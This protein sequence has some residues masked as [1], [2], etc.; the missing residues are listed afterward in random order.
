MDINELL[1]LDKVSASIKKIDLFLSKTSKSDTT[2][3][4][5]IA[6]KGIILGEI[7]RVNEALKLLYA[8]VPIF[9]QLDYNAVIYLCN[10]I[11]YICKNNYLVDQMAKYIEIKK[12]YLPLAR[13]NE[14]KIDLVDYYLL[15]NNQSKIKE[16][17]VKILAEETD[18]DVRAKYMA[19][20]A[21]IYFKE[22]DYER[23][24]S[25]YDNLFSYYNKNLLFDN[26]NEL[27]FK[28][29]RI[30]YE[31]GNYI[32]AIEM[33]KD[34]LNDEHLS[35]ELKINAAAICVRGYLK[36]KEYRRATIIVTDYEEELDKI[37]PIDGKEFVLAALDL[38]KEQ[39][40]LISIKEYEDRLNKI[41]SS[42]EY[43]NPKKKK[44]KQI[45]IPEIAEVI[46]EQPKQNV[47]EINILKNEK[48]DILVSDAYEKF[49]NVFSYINSRDKNLKFRE[50]FRL[51]AIEL[52]KLFPIDEIV[53]V[54][55]NQGYF[56]YHYK[57]ERVYNKAFNNKD[58]EDT[59]L[60]T[61]IE[62]EN[63]AYKEGEG[64]KN[65]ITNSLYEEKK[66]ILCFP[67]FEDTIIMG[68]IA[69]VSNKR[70]IDVDMAYEILKLT[71]QMLNVRLNNEMYINEI[72]ATN[73]KLFFISEAMSS[74]IK[75]EASGY[76][77]S[78]AKACELLNVYENLNTSDYESKIEA[79]DLIMYRKA[80]EEALANEAL[81]VVSRYHFHKGNEVIYV[82]ERFYPMLENKTYT[83]ISLIDDIT[84]EEKTKNDL[85]ALIYENPLSKLSGEAKL[86]IDLTDAIKNKKFSIALIDIN[87]FKLYTDIYGLS[88]T[89]QLI[90]HLGLVIKEEIST[91]FNTRIYHL[92]GDKFALLYLDLNDKRLALSKTLNYLDIFTKKMYDVNKRIKL[93]FAAGVYRYTANQNI[94]DPSKILSY[95][96]YGLLDAKEVKDGLN[97]VVLFDQRSYQKRYFDFQL[98]TH[99]S[100]CIDHNKMKITYKQIIDLNEKNVYAYFARLNLVNYDVDYQ[101]VDKVIKRRSL[102][103]LLDKYL[104]QQVLMELKNFYNMTHAY[105]KICIPIHKKT[106]EDEKIISFI[107]TQLDFFKIPK[108]NLIF[109]ADESIDREVMLKFRNNDL[110]LA[111]NQMECLFLDCLDI[112]FLSYKKYEGS[113]KEILDIALNKKIT[114]ITSDIDTKDDLD[115]A[116]KM[117]LNYIYGDYYKKNITMNELISKV[118]MNN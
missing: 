79:S 58:L 116:K 105:L 47:A 53:I 60:L 43:E 107:L 104:V 11:I 48:T 36:N 13:M 95:A 4:E 19:I 27:T 76:V 70:F 99:I 57:V 93:S 35:S 91:D 44:N 61:T 73:K 92:D 117:N 52:T 50:F 22:H 87:D 85:E 68:S 16:E 63:D 112:L 15:T 30:E 100:E 24:L 66:Y 71:S 1:K 49:A 98:I 26:A 64:L 21:D 39:N 81:D 96:S 75:V 12:N 18:V 86:F 54:Y 67:F 114:I 65:I 109:Y 89:S 45:I 80:K 108:N 74:G 77:H 34:L 2:Y 113:Y 28:K 29:I 42:I 82:K 46:P 59:I 33:A 110:L 55:Y 10:A 20:I 84:A 102:E 41:N 51:G 106:I 62:Q 14:N 94:L 103:D 90:Y 7:G 118:N 23:F 97:H 17:I 40:H 101:M 78:N 69:Y 88:F 8:Y 25:Y 111:T 3:Y 115:K 5:A 38:Y 32:K 56:G 72:E 9:N 37:K 83:L 31:S 6:Y